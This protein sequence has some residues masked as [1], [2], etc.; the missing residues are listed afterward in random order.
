[1]IERITKNEERL[2]KLIELNNELSL[3]IDK[4]NSLK[5][6]IAYL[7]KYYGSSNWLKDKEYYENNNT[8]VKAGVL[9][10]DGVWNALED[11]DYLIKEVDKIVLNY[12]KK[13]Q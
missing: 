11:L 9:S 4:Y 6:E 10:E 5:K 2:D 13:K 8:N 12:N 7:E 1:M 3:S